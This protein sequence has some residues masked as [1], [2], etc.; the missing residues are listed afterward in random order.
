MA[1]G[2]FVGG[3]LGF[4][5][6]ARLGLIGSMMGALFGAYIGAIFDL[7]MRNIRSQ[8]AFS[9]LNP[10]ASKIFFESVFNLMGFLAKLDGRVSEEE[11]QIAEALMIKMGLD[12]AQR[13]SAIAHFSQGKDPNFSWQA[14]LSEL[15]TVCPARSDILQNFLEIL[16][17]LAHAEG[18]L[19]SN[20]EELLQ[21]ISQKLG[22]SQFEYQRL[23]AMYAAQM[24][25]RQNR[26]WQQQ[27]YHY[28]QRSDYRTTYNSPNNQQT[29]QNAYDVLGVKATDS[30]A[31]IKKA[32]RKLMSQ[33]HPDKLAAKG[34][35]PEMMKVATEKTQQIKAAYDQVS[36]ARKQA[37]A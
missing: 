26:Q 16:I 4:L 35:P 20:K 22:F 33:H 15:L 24:R 8:F 18:E 17:E 31:D 9:R 27:Q 5:M 29:L 34:L 21:Q 32:Y 7:G 36:E 3:F 28:Q 23:K 12:E 6:G 2:K 1:L 10:Q 11:I 13:Q 14:V 37:A 19:T 30:D 25:F